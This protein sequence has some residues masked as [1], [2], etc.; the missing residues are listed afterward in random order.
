[1]KADGGDGLRFCQLDKRRPL[2]CI[3]RRGDD[4]RVVD[5]DQ[6]LVIAM[7]HYRVHARDQQC[8]HGAC[9]ARMRTQRFDGLRSSPQ[10]VVLEHPR[11]PLLVADLPMHIEGMDDVVCVAT[12]EFELPEKNVAAARFGGRVSE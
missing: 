12:L 10:I 3:H 1:V 7:M 8:I 6:T 11:E 9:H 2:A 5:P 4:V